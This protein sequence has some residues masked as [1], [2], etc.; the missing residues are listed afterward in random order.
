MFD[1]I[2]ETFAYFIW[3]SDVIILIQCLYLFMHKFICDKFECLIIV[4]WCFV[5]RHKFI[6]GVESFVYI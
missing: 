1:R 6:I 2:S 3:D 5:S 4:L